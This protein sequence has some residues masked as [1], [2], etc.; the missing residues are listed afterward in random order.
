MIRKLLEWLNWRKEAEKN[1]K[2]ALEAQSILVDAL[3]EIN[4]LKAIYEPEKRIY[5]VIPQFDRENEECMARI[6]AVADNQ[7]LFALLFR[8]QQD[9][10]VALEKC[11]DANMLQFHRGRLVMIDEIGKEITQLGQLYKMVKTW[12]KARL[13]DAEI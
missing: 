1:R 4:K 6:S 13:N 12:E 11:A 7:W 3:A 5:T 8:M 10:L 9:S 2:A